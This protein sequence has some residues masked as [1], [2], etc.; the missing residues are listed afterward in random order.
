MAQA[1]ITHQGIADHFDVSRITYSRLV[2]RFRET[3]RTNNRPRNG[4][5]TSPPYKRMI[6]SEAT[7]RRIAGLANVWIVHRRLRE[8]GLWARRPVVGPILKQH[9][10]TTRLAWTRARRC[11]RLHNHTRVLPCSALSPDLS[12]IEHLWDELGRRVRHRTHPPKTLQ[13]L[14]DTLMYECKNIPQAFV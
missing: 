3:S 7:S 1:G 6:T 5:L 10:R 14:R 4:R 13:E 11:W 12:P 2:I 8:S 9:H